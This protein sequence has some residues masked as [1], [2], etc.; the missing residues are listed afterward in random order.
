MSVPSPI[1]GLGV[2]I[3][4]VNP[5]PTAMLSMAVGMLDGSTRRKMSV[6]LSV[7]GAMLGSERFVTVTSL[8]AVASP[9]AAKVMSIGK[10]TS[11][12][13]FWGKSIAAMAAIMMYKLFIIKRNF[14]D[15]LLPQR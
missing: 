6:P 3:G 8:T 13:E 9:R 15:E 2:R 11:P 10:F 1:E 12:H 14:G 5:S 7:T 4:R